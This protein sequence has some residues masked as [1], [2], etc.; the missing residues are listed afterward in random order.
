VT[1]RCIA[2]KTRAKQTNR[3]VQL[4]RHCVVSDPYL[5]I[6]SAID[7]VDVSGGLLSEPGLYIECAVAYSFVVDMSEAG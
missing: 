2:E 7:L 1:I 4:T 6:P 5:L 3:T